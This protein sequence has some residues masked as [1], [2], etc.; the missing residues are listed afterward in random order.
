MDQKINENRSDKVDIEALLLEGHTVRFKPQGYSMY[1]V[2]VP[3]RDEAVVVPVSADTIKRGD[4]VLY[5]RQQS[6]LVLHRV[7]KRNRSGFYMVGD[8]QVETE[9]P[10]SP[11]QIRGKLVALVRKGKEIPVTNPIYCFLTGTWLF[12]RPIRPIFQKSAA[13]IKRVV[14][15]KKG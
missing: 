5:R 8:N 10:L 6:I 1:P 15:G 2:F 13:W 4:V 14:K 7:W 12:L 9:G 11:D 3:G